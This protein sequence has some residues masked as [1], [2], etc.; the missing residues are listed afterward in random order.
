MQIACNHA[1]TLN[2]HM[3]ALDNQANVQR[4]VDQLT[5]QLLAGEYHPFAL[6]NIAEPFCESEPADLIELQHA[7]INGND[8]IVG[9]SLKKFLRTYQETAARKC[10]ENRIESDLENAC[11][12]CFDNG[13]PHCD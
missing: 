10:A 5:D 13:C 4:Q 12:H 2:R 1:S 11:Q 9:T 3:Q 6:E 8:T 7:L